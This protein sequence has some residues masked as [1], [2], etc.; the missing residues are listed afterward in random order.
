MKMPKGDVLNAL[1]T[2]L[3]ADQV[4][5]AMELGFT[6]KEIEDAARIGVGHGVHEYTERRKEMRE[7]ERIMGSFNRD[8]KPEDMDGAY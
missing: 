4:I 1:L 8:T 3:I 2:D 5:R 6:K 7:T